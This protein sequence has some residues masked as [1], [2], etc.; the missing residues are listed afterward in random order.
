M[1]T[2]HEV[3]KQTMPG[4][5]I[6]VVA[7]AGSWTNRWPVGDEFEV[8]EGVRPVADKL[9]GQPGRF[10]SNPHVKFEKVVSEVDAFIPLKDMPFPEVAALM[11][12]HNEGQT[13][14]VRG[15][16]TDWIVTSD[17]DW[18][19]KLQYALA[20][21]PEQIREE[22]LLAMLESI[23]EKLIEARE[24]LSNLNEPSWLDDQWRHMWRDAKGSLLLH[25]HNGGSIQF[26]RDHSW[27]TLADGVKPEWH[28]EAFYRKTPT[29]VIDAE[30]NIA[31]LNDQRNN[32]QHEL[33]EL[34][35]P[36]VAS[37]VDPRGETVT[38]ATA[39]ATVVAFD[40]W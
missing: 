40:E 6:R 5:K 4:D 20:K 34:R 35:A 13:I 15:E 7:S 18:D 26:R 36:K 11:K 31:E 27:I 8:G 38:L 14:K 12:A 3:I 29:N 33:N 9:G 19:G 24:N 30:N 16:M 32:T 37:G 17:P 23:D 1:L 25:S 22:E 21:T 10:W 2:F 39:T 28:D